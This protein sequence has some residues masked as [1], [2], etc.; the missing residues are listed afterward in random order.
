[1]S[2]T[3]A[4][5]SI[6]IPYLYDIVYSLAHRKNYK[7]RLDSRKR[8]CFEICFL[9]YI[10]LFAVSIIMILTRQLW[11][12]LPFKMSHAILFLILILVFTVIILYRS[13]KKREKSYRRRG[14]VWVKST[15]KVRII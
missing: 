6:V 5:D 11:F 8:V 14:M 10:V 7:S 3:D 4:N 1:M 13:Y 15:K 12:I 9:V 2:D